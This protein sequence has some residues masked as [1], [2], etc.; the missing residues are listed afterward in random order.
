MCLATNKNWK[1][2][3][4]LLAHDSGDFWAVH[5]ALPIEGAVSDPYATL[6][7]EHVFHAKDLSDTI[8]QP[9]S[10][11]GRRSA[12][13]P[14]DQLHSHARRTR[15]THSLRQDDRQVGAATAAAN[16]V[17]LDMSTGM[18]VS[19]DCS[20]DTRGWLSNSQRLKICQ[21]HVRLSSRVAASS[22][23]SPVEA[24]EH[25]LGQQPE[26]D[27]HADATPDLGVGVGAVCLVG[28][29][30]TT[31]DSDA[32]G[33]GLESCRTSSR[34]PRKPSRSGR[35]SL[36]EP[37]SVAPASSTA[38]SLPASRSAPGEPVQRLP[39]PSHTVGLPAAKP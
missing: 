35:R 28:Q 14:G 11:R 5:N 26:C 36:R 24:A 39:E 22:G 19:A 8:S 18:P 34:G 3:N 27:T 25:H 32:M 17:V 7:H 33:R 13:E 20:V 2:K 16:L 1:A 37:R 31:T 10:R 6:R 23:A 9:R 21:A 12:A 38:P 29:S 15:S 30:W 4:V